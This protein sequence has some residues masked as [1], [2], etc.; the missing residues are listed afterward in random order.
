MFINE[1]REESLDKATPNSFMF[2]KC[3][4]TSME[5]SPLSFTFGVTSLTD[6]KGDHEP[7]R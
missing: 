5:Q 4:K 7:S 6:D 1:A 2:E 3:M